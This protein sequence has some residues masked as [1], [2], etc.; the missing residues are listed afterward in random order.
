MFLEQGINENNKFWKYLL[1]SVFIIGASFV[2]QMPMLA[3]IFFQT[4][5]KGKTY[6]ENEDQLMHFFEPN[7][8]LFLLLISFVF[9]L[10]GIYCVVRFLHRQSMLSIITSRRKIDW[11][12]ILFSFSIW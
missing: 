9:A 4:F 10:V 7:L 12:R 5:F 8:N 6:P 1:G 11:K 2:G 3:A